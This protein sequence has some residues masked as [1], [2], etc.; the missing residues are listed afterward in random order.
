MLMFEQPLDI[1]MLLVEHRP[2]M[3]EV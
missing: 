2:R 1:D 3:Y